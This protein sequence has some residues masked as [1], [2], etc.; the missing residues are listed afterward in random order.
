MVDS[1]FGPIWVDFFNLLYICHPPPSR[2]SFPVS[3]IRRI[4]TYS[5]FLTICLVLLKEYYLLMSNVHEQ[6]YRAMR[7]ALCRYRIDL[8]NLLNE[9]VS[10]LHTTTYAHLTTFAYCNQVVQV[11]LVTIFCIP[12]RVDFSNLLLVSSSFRTMRI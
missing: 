8:S 3:T 2:L 5:E 1:C 7:E 10:I 9:E 6:K 4:L 12:C 11:A